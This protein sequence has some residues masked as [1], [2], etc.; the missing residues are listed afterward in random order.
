MKISLT[1]FALS[2][3]SLAFA[4]GPDETMFDLQDC[5]VKGLGAHAALIGLQA[6]GK[7]KTRTVTFSDY[8]N[9]RLHPSTESRIETDGGFSYASKNEFEIVGAAG[10]AFDKLLL[11][12]GG[13]N[14]AGKSPN[15]LYAIVGGARKKIAD[16]TCLEV[17]HKFYKDPADFNANCGRQVGALFG[18]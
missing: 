13:T 11:V 6:G 2:V 16:L 4:A 7:V 14:L 3:A 1:V 15:T 12:S 17:E 8:Q 10:T 9:P 18:P 5:V